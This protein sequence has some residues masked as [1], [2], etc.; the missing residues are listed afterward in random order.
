VKT[1]GFISNPLISASCVCSWETVLVGVEF[2]LIDRF[3]QETLGDR[4]FQEWLGEINDEF[5][6]ATSG[7]HAAPKLKPRSGRYK[8]NAVPI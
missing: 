4:S 8:R 1:L 7:L 3:Q 5:G 2:L 6:Y